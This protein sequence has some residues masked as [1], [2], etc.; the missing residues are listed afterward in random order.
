M[1]FPF[2]SPV[3]RRR[4]PGERKRANGLSTPA[5][6]GPFRFSMC[7]YWPQDVAFD[8]L[9]ASSPVKRD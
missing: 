1:S 3:L 9:W 5:A 8:G 7:L 4:D 6:D 2:Y